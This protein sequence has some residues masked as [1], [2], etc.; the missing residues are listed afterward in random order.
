MARKVLRSAVEHL[1][2]RHLRLLEMLVEHGTVRKA[3]E[4]LPASQ[5][6][7]S[8]MLAE[9]ESAFGG[10]L[11]TRTRSGVQPTDRL[12]VLLRR[13]KIVLGELEAASGEL[14]ASGQPV[15]RIGANLQFLTQLL[16]AALA[17]MR[18]AN[19]EVRFLLQ[20]GPSDS[21]IE[22][23]S[24]GSLDCAIARLST[25]SLRDSKSEKE[26]QF[27]PLDAGQ[28]CLVVSRSHPLAKRKQIALEDLAD[29][30]WAL[31]VRNGQGREIIDRIFLDA[32]LRPPQPTIECRP[33]FANLAFAAKMPLV[34]VATRADALSAQEAGLLHILPI[35]ISQKLAPIAFV[36]RKAAA[37]DRWLVQLRDAVSDAA[38]HIKPA[39]I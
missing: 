20:E 10:P 7:A 5:P 38:R 19:P 16:P 28:L 27:W 22:A 34:T 15:I 26:L 13:I 29:E 17:R 18:N 33:Q 32:G 8:Q 35:D 25:R 6:V 14:A 24:E 36:C 4:R 12:A 1:R 2:L 3:A 37:N 30:H 9:L 11:F 21:L 31:G 23:L 39:K